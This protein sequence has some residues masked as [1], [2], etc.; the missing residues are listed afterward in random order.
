MKEVIRTE[1]LSKRYKDILA[2]ENINLQVK[3]GEICG[4]LGVN[5]AGKTTTIRLLLGMVKPTSG[6]V[7][8]FNKELKQL[9]TKKW[10]E[11]GYLVEDSY[12]YPQLTVKENLEI[13]YKLRKLNNPSVINEIISKLKLDKY[14]DVK[15][16]NLS[17]GNMQRL[18]LAKAFIHKPK[19]LLL[20]EPTKG[21]DPAGIVEIRI[22]LKEL[23]EKYNTTIFISSH[24]LSE[25]YK[26]VDRIIIINEG[27]ILRDVNKAKLDKLMQKKLIINTNDN[28]KAKKI[29]IN[30]GYDIGQN[31]KNYLVIKDNTIINS[32]EQIV[33]KL[34][35]NNIFPNLIN[36]EK[37]DLENYFLRL[38]KNSIKEQ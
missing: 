38:T 28:L 13:I 26:L 1:Y 35:S 7:Y 14:K 16:K 17:S 18:G 25:I 31:E 24:I 29:M 23:A 32:P 9:P 27:H 21:L 3:R 33:K 20:D 15:V 30:E 12:S 19:I 11:V 37:E 10:N 22:L 6:S 8:L 2:V 34:V 36:I 5:G 4:F